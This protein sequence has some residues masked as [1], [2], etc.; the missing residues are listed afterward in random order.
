MMTGPSV[1]V[2]AILF[3]MA[4]T[5]TA[6]AANPGLEDDPAE[7]PRCVDLFSKLESGPDGRLSQ[8]VEIQQRA[9]PKSGST[10]MGN[11]ANGV[12]RGT[13]DWLNSLY[14]SETCTII[15]TTAELWQMLFDPSLSTPDSACSCDEIDTVSITLDLRM[16][17]R[18]PIDESCPWWHIHGIP[19]S[20]DACRLDGE[21]RDYADLMSCVKKAGCDVTDTRLQFA[22]LRDP[23]AMTVSAYFH[24]L[25]SKRDRDRV[26]A[27]RTIDEYFRDNLAATCQWIALRLD[28]GG[29]R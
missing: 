6:T 25:R 1:V 13:C 21:I 23:R 28:D 5:V 8:M 20:S 15:P 27:G 17:H 9:A 12:L 22:T 7:C 10:M 19:D 11:R 2:G 14:G 3:V 18:L 16:K 24:L 29:Y 26:I 4:A